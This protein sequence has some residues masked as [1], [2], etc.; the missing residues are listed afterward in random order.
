M[1]LWSN[2]YL[3][4]LA[5]KAENECENS[6]FC[7]NRIIIN[8]NADKKNLIHDFLNFFLSLFTYMSM[9]ILNCQK[10]LLNIKISI[11]DS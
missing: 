5:F 6:L 2:N 11:I 3:Y 8:V 1:V 10:F 4:R 7:K 9:I